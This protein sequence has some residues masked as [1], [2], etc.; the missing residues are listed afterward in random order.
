MFTYSILNSFPHTGPGDKSK[1]QTRIGKHKQLAQ[2]VLSQVKP[3]FTKL[4]FSENCFHNVSLG[5]FCVLCAAEEMSSGTSAVKVCDGYCCRRR[6]FS[7]VGTVSQAVQ[8]A[9]SQ[10]VRRH[11]RTKLLKRCSMFFFNQ[12]QLSTQAFS[13]RST[14]LAML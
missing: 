6:M 14:W 2:L 9:M 4:A 13:S 11:M 10:V 8:G 5:V 7:Y 3:L 1:S 12:L